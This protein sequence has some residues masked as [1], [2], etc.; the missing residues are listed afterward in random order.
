[1]LTK[2]R[3]LLFWHRQRDIEALSAEPR[4]LTGAFR[5]ERS[6]LP[7]EL[8]TTG[9]K[10]RLYPECHINGG[11][12]ASQ[13][14][15]LTEGDR[16]FTGP[17]QFVRL[18][19]GQKI[20]QGAKTALGAEQPAAPG[21]SL[22]SRIE[23]ENSDGCILLRR[24]S[25]DEQI[26][27]RYIEDPD[28][29]SRPLASRLDNLKQVR[30]L[31][32]GAISLARPDQ[33]LVAVEQVNA[34]LSKEVYR[35]L[36]QDGFPGG[37]LELPGEPTPVI[38]GDLHARVDNLLKV[39]SEGGLLSALS[40]GEAILVLLGD[41]VHPEDEDE[42]EQMDS[43]LLMLDLI[44]CL[45]IAYPRNVFYLR[46][47]HDSFDEEVGKSGVAQG[48]LLR[49][50]AREL[51]GE[52]YEAAL[53]RFFDLLPYAV[54]SSDFIACHGGPPL[55]KTTREALINIRHHPGL[56]RELTWNRPRRPGNAVGY[57]KRS[58]KAFRKALG[59]DVGTPF[60]VG[61]TPLSAE[62]TLWLEAGGIANHH[63]LYSARRHKVAA[64]V[65]V[66]GR[67]VPLEY[68]GESLIASVNS[69]TLE[70]DIQVARA[71]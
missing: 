49:R 3:D 2:V 4:N 42:L 33:A 64:F 45:K 8:S 30:R 34:I 18:E 12:N 10:L 31:M 55:G 25:G 60:I 40:Q 51:R 26:L 66:D 32:G 24:L 58:V 5:A 22:R 1:M 11:P 17:A 19:P 70:D 23:I 28:E 38:L 14:W 69:L 44:V 62:G 54:K 21:A 63:I 48:V 6:G 43:S 29:V 13:H 37:L 50:R 9:R 20:V 7:I 53:A 16:Y 67:L 56:A 71:S 46:G 27:A 52:R 41:A 65:R 57:S 39:L 61:H 59:A 47:N 68:S 36:D 15:I 35:P